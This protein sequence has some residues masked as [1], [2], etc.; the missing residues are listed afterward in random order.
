MPQPLNKELLPQQLA[1]LFQ[2]SAEVRVDHQKKPDYISPFGTNPPE[3]VVFT[4]NS[5]RKAVLMYWQLICEY[6]L[7][8]WPAFAAHIPYIPE[9]ISTALSV[10]S[11]FETHIHNG[12]GKVR[13]PML[14][15][16][17]PDGTPVLLCPTD[18]ESHDNEDPILEA[19]RKI[20][21][22]KD[23]FVGRDVVFIS[24]DAV[25]HIRTAG[26]GKLGKPM[27][28]P[29]YH[30]MLK[31]GLAKGIASEQVEESFIEAYK[32]KY[33]SVTDGQPLQDVHLTGLVVERGAKKIE[34]QYTLS[35]EVQ[36]WMIEC[37]Q[38]CMDMGG[39]GVFQQFIDLLAE[40][41]PQIWL[42]LEP[43]ETTEHL[44]QFDEKLWP[45]VIIF[46]IMG[47]PAMIH[48]VFKE[49]ANESEE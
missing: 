22:V 6:D 2:Q 11:Y 49:V 1:T 20:N 7:N 42:K 5:L 33:Y 27:N 19:T 34:R 29:M 26:E 32:A 3:A 30:E 41:D 10:H 12:D 9:E 4:S 36:E 15:G 45:Y 24:S 8:S 17:L 48:S 16:L 23:F 35:V 47:M 38:V 21:D 39:G 43:T 44:L 46:Q 40:T 13:E 14:L 31:L 37:V 28:S 18:G 25:Q